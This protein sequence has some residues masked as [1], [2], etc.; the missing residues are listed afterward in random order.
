MLPRSRINDSAI[1]DGEHASALAFQ[2]DLKQGILE[3]LSSQRIAA[4]LDAPQ[5]ELPTGCQCLAISTDAEQSFEAGQVHEGEASPGPCDRG[6]PLLSDQLEHL[7]Q[8]AVVDAVQEKHPSD[9]AREEVAVTI[10]SVAAHP[11]CGRALLVVMNVPSHGSLEFYT[12]HLFMA[13]K[14]VYY[15]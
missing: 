2:R 8:L 4:R 15:M 11:S 14:M 12:I 7:S 1:D 6:Q 9:L 10:D 13:K 5:A 3:S